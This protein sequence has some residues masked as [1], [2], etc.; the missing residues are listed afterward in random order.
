MATKDVLIIAHRGASGYLPEH[1]LEAKAYAY[2]L[3]ADYLEQDLA[4]TRDDELVV[5]HDIHLDRVTNVA[6]VFPDRAR[7]DGRFYVR[8]FDLVEI[9]QLNA[10]ERR[11]GDN[12]TAVFPKRFPTSGGRF[13]VPTLAEEITLIQ[14]LNRSTGRNVGIYPEIKRPAWHKDNGVDISRLVIGM[15]AEFGYR[16][17]SDAVFLQCFDFFECRRIRNDLGCKL[18]LIQLL[19]QPGSA[20]A[21]GSDYAYLASKEGL[22]EI[23]AFAN[24][25][26]PWLGHLIKIA[27]IDG[28]PVSSGFVSMA[29]EL[30]LEVHPWTFRAEQLIPG[31]DTLADMVRWSVEELKIDGLFTD[32]PDQARAGLD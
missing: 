12:S 10:H 7:D 23:S 22:A 15:L 21:T 8:D 30:K 27:D 31:F 11:R 17:V 1:T 3:G 6:E 20:E 9:R 5:I 2:A 25:V 32:F 29:H 14:G 4:A 16:D 19:D 26:G 18:K 28:H 13:T 24:G